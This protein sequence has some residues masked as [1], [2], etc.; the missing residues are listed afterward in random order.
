MIFCGSHR[1]EASCGPHPC[2]PC[3]GHAQYL[4]K[5]LLVEGE[6]KCDIRAYALLTSDYRIYLYRE[7]VVRTSAVA[8]SLDDLSDTFAHLSNHCIAVN[9]PEYGKY[10]PTNEMWWAELDNW[11]VQEHGEVHGFYKCALP[12]IKQ[13]V[14]T[15]LLAA[16]CQMQQKDYSCFQLF[17]FDLM[18][19]AAFKVGLIE[20]NSSPAVPAD[21]MA[22]MTEDLVHLAIDPV[23][24]LPRDDSRKPLFQ[25][26]PQVGAHVAAPEPIKPACARKPLS[27]WCYPVHTI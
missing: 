17:G 24:P 22:G 18:V 8:Y 20:V 25:S 5:P 6:R 21:L 7:G 19:D 9:H 11:M 13:I 15:T 4:E 23:F 27:S 16:R 1:P 3:C 2:H 12:Q 26:D 14:V 10:E